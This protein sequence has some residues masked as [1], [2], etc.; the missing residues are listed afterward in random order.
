MTV[1]VE[2]SCVPGEAGCRVRTTLSSKP[3]AR[4]E[5]HR[6]QERHDDALCHTER[7]SRLH[8]DNVRCRTHHDREHAEHQ[9]EGEHERGNGAELAAG[10]AHHR[11]HEQR[12]ED[13]GDDAEDDEDERAGD[14]RE[15]IEPEDAPGAIAEQDDA[16][17]VEGARGQALPQPEGDQ[18]AG[19]R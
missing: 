3:H 2:L 15:W 8:A 13:A 4:Y 14:A 19:T 7:R 18:G 1:R 11:A 9:R 5:T 16:D 6:E 17:R 10:A 12:E